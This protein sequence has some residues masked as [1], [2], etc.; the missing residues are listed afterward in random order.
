MPIAA[1]IAN[2]GPGILVTILNNLEKI[3]TSP[4]VSL[5][6]AT[7]LKP[8][9]NCPPLPNH[10]LD[11]EPN[12]PPSKIFLTPFQ[13][14]SPVPILLV[15]NPLIPPSAIKAAFKAIVAASTPLITPF[16]PN[17]I[18][19]KVCN[20]IAVLSKPAAYIA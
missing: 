17:R 7:A 2:I 18:L 12:F 19:L 20:A 10:L 5:D 15:K 3:D 14:L 1:P 6:F 13:P 4:D 11:C 9:L 16:N 8:E